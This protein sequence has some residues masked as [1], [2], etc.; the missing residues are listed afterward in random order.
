MNL[1]MTLTSMALLG[2]EWVMWLLVALSIGAL[3]VIVERSLYFVSSRENMPRLTANMV[4]LLRRGQADVARKRLQESPGL[5][6]RVAAAGLEADLDGASERMDAERLRVK[7]LMDRNLAFLGTLGN[8]AP[9]VGLLGTVIGV[10]GAFS[11]LAQ[12]GA[13]VSAGLMAEIGEALVVTGLG[14]VVALPAVASFNLF[15]R[16]IRTRLERADALAAQVLAHL[17]ASQSHQPLSGRA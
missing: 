10:V 2:A 9:F 1:Q 11:E 17:K 5:E 6:A 16:V 13:Q 7:L 14:L 4:D 12:G 3:A 8:N 15:Q